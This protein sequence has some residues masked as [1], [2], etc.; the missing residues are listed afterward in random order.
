MKPRRS[1][2]A[3]GRGHSRYFD[4]RRFW[5]AL[6]WPALRALAPGGLDFAEE[7]CDPGRLEATWL[8]HPDEAALLLALPAAFG[9]P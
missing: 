2:K 9:A 3:A 7:I 8:E 1:P 5:A 4:N 6:G